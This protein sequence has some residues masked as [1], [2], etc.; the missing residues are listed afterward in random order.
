[1]IRTPRDL[2][3]LIRQERINAGLDQQTLANRAGVSRLWI[4]E[5]ERGKPGASVGRVL[6]TLAVLGVE[7]RPTLIYAGAEDQA[8]RRPNSADFI[9]HV[10][11]GDRSGD[12]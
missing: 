1:M 9:R 7:L 6:K 5:V 3:A 12:E 2:G 11:S 10:L 8:G 4:N